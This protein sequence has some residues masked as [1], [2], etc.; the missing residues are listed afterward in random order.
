VSHGHSL[1]SPERPP[2][3]R[4][5]LPRP[6][7][8][9]G[10]ATAVAVGVPTALFLVPA[11]S[12]ADIPTG[13]IRAASY[14]A[15]SGV[16]Q[17][18]SSDAGGG[19]SV[20]WLSNGDWMRFDD[21]D[22]GAAGASSTA[23]RYSAAYHDRTGSVELR[24]D[25]QAGPLL[26]DVPVTATNGWGDWRTATVDNQTPGGKHS[27]FLVVKSAQKMDFVN[28]NWFTLSGATAAPTAPTT[29][30]PT[31][32]PT[33][34]PAT[35]PTTA[36]TSSAPPSQ[37]GWIDVDPARW[38]KQLDAFDALKEQSPRPNVG[39]HSEFNAFCHFSHA[40][41]DD[42]IVFHGMP[43]ASHMHS[44]EGNESLDANS[45]P[46]DMV[47]FTASSCEP[48]ADHSAYWVPELEVKDDQGTVTK[49][50]QP[51]SF[52]VYYGNNTGIKDLSV[53]KPVPFGL[54]MLAGDPK[55]TRPTPAGAYGQFYCTLGDLGGV[56]RTKD[57]NFPICA[58]DPGNADNPGTYHFFLT[59]PQCWDGKH[60]DSPNHRDHM[61]SANGGTCPASHPIQIPQ[62]AFSISYPTFGQEGMA[63]ASGVA[64]SMHGDVLEAW[65]DDAMNKRTK[66]CAIPAIEC[67]TNEDHKGDLPQ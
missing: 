2:A 8:L 47:K 39:V 17:E 55:S 61:A 14:A 42:P 11:A 51:N 27:V 3:R 54:R 56:S 7:V 45:T 16:Q 62:I 50:I 34:V 33:T 32:V 12:A 67:R 18:N 48:A 20:G 46:E 49:R 9:I 35:D 65:D 22:L 5:R 40:L 28:L 29:A 19:K 10:A 44:I 66:Y 15:Q 63:L 57:G 25:S 53:T 6:A 59:F 38:K 23:L 41:P 60:L 21:V 31:T 4:R 26:A 43:G 37:A 64:S 58:K 1:P 13:A 36:P 52:I 24:L 30:P